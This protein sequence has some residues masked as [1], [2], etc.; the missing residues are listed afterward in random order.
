MT[1]LSIAHGLS[2][3]NLID[4]RGRFPLPAFG[5]NVVNRTI[6]Y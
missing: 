4:Y 3:P 6:A 1:V 5:R 2:W